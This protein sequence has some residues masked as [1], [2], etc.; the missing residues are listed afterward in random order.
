MNRYQP[1]FTSLFLIVFLS[2][3]HT[4]ESLSIDYMLP[5]EVSFPESLKRVA[6]VNNMPARSMQNTENADTCY[7]QGDALIAIEALAETLAAENYFEEVVVCDSALCTTD[8]CMQETT[9]SMEKSDL[10]I[11]ELDVDF[12]IALEELPIQVIREI[13]YIPEIKL[14]QG[15]TDAKTFPV[16]KVYLPHRK[17][18]MVTVCCN[19]SIFWKENFFTQNYTRNRLIGEEEVIKQASDFAGTLPVKH[20]LPTWNTASR[21]LFSGGS[22]NMRDAIVCA[23]EGDWEQAIRLWEPIFHK[24][25]G[26]QKMYAAYNIALGY[27]MQDSISTA[28]EW[29]VE[30]QKIA[31][32]IDKVDDM[33]INQRVNSYYAPNYVMTNIYVAELK[34]RLEGLARL[35]M[36]MNRFIEE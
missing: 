21:Y 20:L 4:I 1:F 12:L 26:K 9:L 2:A 18:P 6:V 17:A 16:V 24:K 25:K 36:Q 33:N 31:K 22:V 5:A 7:Y 30:A 11:Q 3:C 28:Y 23:R 27:E 29:A 35:N 10:L 13:K 8:S 34:K 19:D 14:F 32:Q 15:T